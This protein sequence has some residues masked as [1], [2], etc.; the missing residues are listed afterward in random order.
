[1][2]SASGRRSDDPKR[3]FQAQYVE[4]AVT[5]FL[6]I[7]ALDRLASLWDTGNKDEYADLKGE[8]KSRA[9]SHGSAA[10]RLWQR[11]G[12]MKRTRMVYLAFALF[13]LTMI[14]VRS[15]VFAATPFSVFGRSTEGAIDQLGYRSVDRQIE[16][17]PT[18]SP[19]ATHDPDMADNNLHGYR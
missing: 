9:K 2:L 8:G 5:K 11:L 18:A 1:M 14:H 13:T 17:A 16:R 12:Y 6:K 10:L 3:K 4:R 7:F 19:R 15:S